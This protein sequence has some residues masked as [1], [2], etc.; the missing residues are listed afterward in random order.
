MIRRFDFKEL[1][2]TQDFP[3]YTGA[4]LLDKADFAYHTH[5]FSEIALIT[6]GLSR[7]VVNGKSHRIKT[8]DLFVFNGQAAHAFLDPRS[9][10]V[11]NLMYSPQFFLKEARDLLKMPG[12]HALF[13]LE[14]HFHGK[15]EYRSHLQLSANEL[16]QT[17]EQM[18]RIEQEFLC[19][20]DGREPMI[21]VL[22][23]ELVI[24]LSRLYSQKK[25]SENRSDRIGRIAE[26]VAY[27]EN[28]FREPIKL[29]TLAHKANLSVSQFQRIFKDIYDVPPMD[30]ILRKRV[31]LAC[32]IIRQK[33]D[34][35]ISIAHECGFSD[36][37]YFARQ[38]RKITGQTPS[39][40]RASLR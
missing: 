37:N 40:Y 38:F 32:E 24:S 39:E 29:E 5:E 16:S 33:D 4:T 30:Y 35:I 9:L 2:V 26:A 8:G 25:L 21:R 6:G 19:E 3:F 18:R 12:Y 7:H 10:K 11:F 15:R 27:L 22:F 28:Q 20:R 1:G 14:P 13:K 31:R 17:E 34:K 36:S 23:L